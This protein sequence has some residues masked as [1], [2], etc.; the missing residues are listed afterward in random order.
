MS[1][2]IFMKKLV[3]FLA[4]LIGLTG[5]SQIS[6]WDSVAVAGVLGYDTTINF[7][8]IQKFN[9]KMYVGG[10]SAGTNT[11]TMSAS[12]NG[13][14][15][16]Y[17]VLPSF[18]SLGA[19]NYLP[20]YGANI[21]TSTAN[22]NYLFIGTGIS[23]G[24][25]GPT[26]PQVYRMDVAENFSAIGP[27]TYTA[28][29]SDNQVSTF[30]FGQIDALAQYSPTG[31]NDTVYS[32]VDPNNGSNA[33]SVWKAPVNTPTPTW[34]NSTNFTM[35]SG[36]TEVYDA[37]VWHNRLYIATNRVDSTDGSNYYPIGLILS[38]ANGSTWDTVAKT[39]NLVYQ[40]N[41]Y[42]NS[43]TS[44]A[45]TALEIHNDTLI[46]AI[47]NAGGPALWYTADHTANP[48]WTNMYNNSDLSMSGIT[49]LQSD[50]YN[51]WIETSTG[52]N[53]NIYQYNRDIV[54]Q[55]LFLPQVT[56]GTDLGNYNNTFSYKMQLYSNDLYTAGNLSYYPSYPY[57]A[58]NIWRLG[59][60]KASFKDSLSPNKG[61]CV[62]DT[63][64]LKNTSTNAST[65][66][67]I[68]NSGY[69]NVGTTK[70]TA[71]VL[72]NAGTYNVQLKVFSGDVGSL[73][74]SAFK[75]ITVHPNPSVTTLSALPANICAGQA[76]TLK[77]QV[78][79]LIPYT[80]TWSLNGVLT[81]TSN[82]DSIVINPATPGIYP[83]FV[84]VQDTNKCVGA[85]TATAT[86]TV[87]QNNSL[88]GF[89]TRPSGASV[90]SGEAYLFKKKTTNVGV[91][92][93]INMVPIGTYPVNS[94][95]Y[96]YSFTN[97]PVGNYYIKVIADTITYPFSVGTYYSF[98]PNRFQW[99]SAI[100]I[101][102]LTCNAG[103][104]TANIKII[105]IKDTAGPGT[106]SGEIKLLAS[107]GQRLANGGN[108]SVYGSPLKG[109]DVKLGKSPGGGCSA[110]TTATTTA[111][112]TSGAIYTY[113]FDSIPLGS[114]KIYVDIPNYG[115]DSA[116]V[117]TITQVDTASIN[118]NY[119]VDSTIIHVDTTR[120]LSGIFKQSAVNN[121]IQVYPNPTADVAYL[122]FENSSPQNVNLQLYDIAG[123]QLAVL[124]ND[125]M[126]RGRQTVTINLAGLNL[127][128][129][130]YFIRAT[131]N[132]ALQTLK[133]TIISH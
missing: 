121:S 133:L 44:Y 4:L 11:L 12:P 48:T 59:I 50:G 73:G 105:E 79:S 81:Y 104:D 70:D 21:T 35:A 76:D 56:A 28:L 27:F 75:T 36:I 67:W 97:V 65:Y 129:G 120:I 30:G 126:P 90:M 100:V 130:V 117:A 114:Y 72:G 20:T 39:N 1:K 125:K 57:S 102:H 25:S 88:S 103:N 112:T 91:A 69:G 34:I 18:V 49:D 99:D 47:D 15:G 92:D 5:K 101:N 115:M 26:I 55:T 98:K 86:V 14:L 95:N 41:G 7:T 16:T 42:Y 116:R 74:D 132:G 77:T 17:T 64:F 80:A 106:I 83:V 87:H 8:I 54:T 51:I 127:D 33:I 82:A 118:N 128:K 19:G 45:F 40:A 62:G 61:F 31:S 122:D 60:P 119:Y 3:L 38:T 29:P 46:A 71:Y 10:R 107:F 13:N 6:N 43:Y 96:N 58:G 9:N 66:N 109:I 32:F 110:R 63:L 108:N 123:K 24:G 53:L 22:N 113:Q 111:T 68:F 124:Y 52:Y 131:I 93:T 78:L 2:I 94:V 85:S 23:S 37:A 89:I 84:T